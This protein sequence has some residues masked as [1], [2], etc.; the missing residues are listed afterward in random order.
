MYIFIHYLFIK[1]KLVFIN[2]YYYI[3]KP[4]GVARIHFYV[5]EWA[6]P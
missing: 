6:E 3:H 5:T 4:H 1:E 2:V